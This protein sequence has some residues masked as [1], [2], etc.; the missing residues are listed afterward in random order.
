M[1]NVWTMDNTVGFTQA[2]LDVVNAVIERL[3]AGNEDL[4]AYDVNSALTNEWYE[5]ISEAELYEAAA[6]RLGVT[7][8]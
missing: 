5:G 7:R 6:K 2:E 8:S 3:M 4:E 1:C